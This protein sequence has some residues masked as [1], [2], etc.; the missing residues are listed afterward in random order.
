VAIFRLVLKLNS[1]RRA[2]CWRAVRRLGGLQLAV[3]LSRV[4][5]VTRGSGDR[6]ATMQMVFASTTAVVCL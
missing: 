5:L 6:R 4:E 1:D 2:C 3:S